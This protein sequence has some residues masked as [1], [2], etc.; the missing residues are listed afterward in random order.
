MPWPKART[1]PPMAPKCPRHRPCPACPCARK[2]LAT[3]VEPHRLPPNCIIPSL[4][5]ASRLI[6]KEVQCVFLLDVGQSLCKTI[7]EGGLHIRGLKLDL[8]LAWLHT[9]QQLMG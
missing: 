4:A 1:P 5:D 9:L 2:Q 6:R 7:K 8:H 3:T